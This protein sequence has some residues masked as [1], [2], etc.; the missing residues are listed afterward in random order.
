MG[1]L[2]NTAPYSTFARSNRGRQRVV[3]V[4]ANDG[5]LHAFDAGT[6]TDGVYSA[7]TGD[8]LF[9][10]V[11]AKVIKHLPELTH[12]RYR[13][14][15]FVDGTPRIGDAFDGTQWRT[16]LVGGLRGGG[17][18]IYALDV[19]DPGSINEST[20]D[21]AVLWEFT[22]EDHADMGYSFS[23]PLITRMNNGKWAAIVA[24]GYGSTQSD[25]ASGSG[26]SA[27]FV[28]DLFTG[29]LLARLTPNT[30]LSSHNG[31]S[32]PTAVDLNGDYIADIIYA[33]DLAGYVHAFDVTGSSAAAWVSAAAS[34]LPLFS[35]QDNKGNKRPI[36]GG[37]SVGSHPTGTGVMLYFGTG[38]YLE[39]GDQ[40]A[41]TDKNRI[42]GVWDKRLAT[43]GFDLDSPTNDLLQQSITSETSMSLDTDDDSV[44]DT[45]VQVRKS[46][47]NSIDWSTNSGWYIDLTYPTAMGEQVLTSPV[48][49]D[50]KLF[51]S[52]HAP[53]GVQCDPSEQGWLMVVNPAD[54]A[55]LDQTPFDLDDDD[56]FNGET[57]ISGFSNGSNP[58]AELT[59][60][61]ASTDDVI[62]NQG[63]N[64]PTLTSR[65]V[66]ASINNGMVTWREIEP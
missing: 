20:A 48:L 38:K 19:T 12:P 18:G 30:S 63:S 2:E 36:T 27:I 9:A 61:S 41:S 32:Q 24:N 43:S 4:G 11:P 22:D 5:M 66:D 6:S 29:E 23:T 33:G 60:S 1:A 10:Y 15:Y 13:H 16:V 58:F 51:I 25:G 49:R 64:D 40:A 50:G 44:D 31:M 45:I 62:L 53:S 26:K 3:Y 7:G 21:D 46:T 47:S 52:T 42:Y 57:P 8:E 39:Y 28:L 55:M 56:S 14:K 37:I 35:A 59:F 54:G 34:T 65:K 17:Q